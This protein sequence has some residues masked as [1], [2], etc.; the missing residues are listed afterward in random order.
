[1]KRPGSARL[2]SEL[3]FAT[4]PSWLRILRILEIVNRNHIVDFACTKV[5]LA[6]EVDG[7]AH[8]G[9]EPHNAQRDRELAAL[10]WEVVHIP[11]ELLFANLE[12]AV[13]RILARAL[14]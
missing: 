7:G 14:R 8:H 6:V 10:G 4:S 12:E 3:V 9:R 2:E 13:R 11:E 5:R 1:M